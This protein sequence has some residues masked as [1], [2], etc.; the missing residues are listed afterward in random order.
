MILEDDAAGPGLAVSGADFHLPESRSAFHSG[1]QRSN[2][3]TFF[4]FN[5]CS[6]CDPSPAAH[7]AARTSISGTL[8]ARRAGT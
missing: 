2:S 6:T 1:V 3:S 7:C 8:D 5:Q 4:S